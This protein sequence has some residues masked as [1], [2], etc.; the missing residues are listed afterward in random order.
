MPV[1]EPATGS[2]FWALVKS[3]TEWP[4]TDE[5]AVELLSGSWDQAAATFAEAARTDVNGLRASWGDT[6]GELFRTRAKELFETAEQ[7]ERNMREFAVETAD[8][9]VD[10]RNT[11]TAIRDFVLAGDAAFV[12]FGAMAPEIGGPLQ[13]S[14]VNQTA[15]EINRY[16]DDVAGKVAAGSSVLLSPVGPGGAPPAVP[17]PPPGST[18]A[19]VNQWWNGLS[20]ADRA[21]VLRHAP[22]TVRNLD[23][24]PAVVRDAAN[25]EVLDR[26]LGELRARRHDI[27]ER[28]RLYGPPGNDPHGDMGLAEV[29]AKADGLD[30]IKQRLDHAGTDLRPAYL[31]GLDPRDDGKA[32]VSMGNP[33]TAANVATFV[34][35]MTS[36]LATIGGNLG[37]ADTIAK[38]AGGSTAVVTWL[39]YDAPDFVDGAASESYADNGKAALNDFQDGLRATHVGPASHNTVVAHSYGTTLVG[40]TARDLGIN[41]DEVVLLASPGTGAD[42]VTDLH[43]DGVGQAEVGNHVHATVAKNDIINEANGDWDL[44]HGPSPADSDFGARVFRSADGTASWQN[45]FTIAAHSEYFN[46]RTPTG[47]ENPA[48]D[49]VGDV[50]ANRAPG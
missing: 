48:L 46:E 44:A 47:E 30:A 49:Y 3:G 19:Q 18:P 39:G 13:Q 16:L 12:T 26:E 7:T 37:V 31:L 8:F 29:K 43:L 50:V 33:D 28:L 15:A 42:E 41:A 10:V 9:A 27:E 23:G 45:G 14:L 1:E 6:N 2:G 36:D 4:D 11:K 40:H 17:A 34:P 20:E 5:D 22:D 21:A 24:I 35:G 25:R 32:V 38:E